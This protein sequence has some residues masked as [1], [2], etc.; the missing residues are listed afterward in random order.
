MARKL[1]PKQKAFVSEY[2]IDLN[3]TQAAVRAGYS[4]KT[5]GAIGGENLE[6]PEIQE[7]IQ[8]AT[9]K[10]SERTE[11]TQ[12]KVIAEIAKYAFKDASDAP[13]SA[14]KHSSKTKY[15]DMLCKH[16]GAYE[17]GAADNQNNIPDDP[18]SKALKEEA[19]RME[20]ENAD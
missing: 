19:E 4:K 16:L 14:F 6:K 20:D 9:Y 3:A 11:I 7:A 17:R 2:L 18:L 15:I 12:D 5:A 13:E 1:T 8:K 10:R